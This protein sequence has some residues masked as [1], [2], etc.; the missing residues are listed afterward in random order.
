MIG[1][2]G[3][4]GYIGSNLL[5]SCRGYGLDAEGIGKDKTSGKFDI[6][7]HLATKYVKNH[8][9]DDLYN[10]IYANYWFGLIW[11]E[12]AYRTGA[13]FIYTTS[14][15]ADNPKSLYG[16]QK[17]QFGEMVE[18]YGKKGLDYCIVKIFNTFGPEDDRDLFLTKVFNGEDVS[19]FDLNNEIKFTHVD[20]VCDFLLSARYMNGT[21][22]VPHETG[23]VGE[24]I[25]RYRHC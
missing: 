9:T 23:T 14:Y 24:F 16:M 19:T 5:D 17:K 3:A 1:I 22:E 13:K 12:Q 20:T 15:F 2:T 10:M 7:Y 25:E 18:F 11:L 8:T 6:I 4:T 21:V